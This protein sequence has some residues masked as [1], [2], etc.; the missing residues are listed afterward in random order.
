MQRVWIQRT[1]RGNRTRACTATIQS[2][3]LR[4]ADWIKGHTER[5]NNEMKNGYA[6]ILMAGVV[7]CVAAGVLAY[8]I[9]KYS[10]PT[11]PKI[12]APSSLLVEADA[13]CRETPFGTIP[14]EKWP[15]GIASLNP[16]YVTTSQGHLCVTI[17]TGGINPSWG[18]LIFPDG[19]TDGTAEIGLR[20]LGTTAPGIF[21]FEAIE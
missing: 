7:L 14:K 18:Y 9:V 20:V 16:Q 8:P 17:S 12:E 15:A 19:R 3:P 11:W 6:S 2:A 4:V 5:S 1:M 13:I 21:R 10:R